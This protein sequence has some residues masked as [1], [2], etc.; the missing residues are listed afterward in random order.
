MLVTLHVI[1]KQNVIKCHHLNRK[2][3]A[4]TTPKVAQWKC[5]VTKTLGVYMN[6]F[7]YA[8]VIH[9]T[10]TKVHRT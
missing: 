9:A 3:G 8:K 6:Q 10:F 5:K 2:R 1:I 7:C 4:C